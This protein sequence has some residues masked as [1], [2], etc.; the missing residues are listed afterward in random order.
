MKMQEKAMDQWKNH[1]DAPVNRYHHLFRTMRGIR[2]EK[3]SGVED[4]KNILL[5]LRNAW[6]KKSVDGHWKETVPPR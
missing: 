5:F 6:N 3:S 4:I 1:A 2:N